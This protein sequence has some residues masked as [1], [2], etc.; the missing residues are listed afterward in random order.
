MNHGRTGKLLLLLA[1]SAG[2]TLIEAVLVYVTRTKGALPF[3]IKLT[4][5]FEL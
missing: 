3:K 5:D 2:L 1:V 4:P